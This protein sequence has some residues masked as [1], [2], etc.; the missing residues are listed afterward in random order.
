MYRRTL[1]S[2][3]T[4]GGVAL[5]TGCLDETENPHT[6]PNSTSDT[7]NNEWRQFQADGAHTGATAMAGPD[8]GGRIRWWSNTWGLSTAPVI[9]D[10]TVYAGTGLQNQLVVALDE[11]TGDTQWEA[12]IGDDIARALAVNDGTVYAA[13]SGVYALN[14]ETGEQKWMDHLDTS[15]GLAFADDTVFTA[16]GGGGPLVALDVATG[17][18]RWHREIHTIT[19]PTV[20]DGRVFAVGN[21]DLLA[22]D[23]ETGETEW[24]KE[25]DRAGGPPTVANGTVFVGTRGDLIAHDAATGDRDWTLPGSFR[26]TDIAA[27][28]DTLYF[29]GRQREDDEWIG[30]AFAVDTATGEVEWTYGDDHLGAG[31][32]VGTEKT[33]YVT[34]RTRIYA[35][36]RKTGDLEWWLRFQWPVSPPAIADETLYV[37]VGGRVMAIES[38]DGHAGVWPS[39]AEP[40]P[41]RGAAPAEPTYAETDFSFGMGG[42]D[43]RSESDVTVDEDA[44]VAVSFAIDGDGVDEDDTVSISLAIEN[45]SDEVLSFNTGAP[46]PFGIFSLHDDAQNLVAWTPA[47]EETT[48][49]HTSPHLGI[50]GVNSIGLSTAIQPGDTVRETYSI[51]DETHGIQPGTYEFSIEQTLFPADRENDHDGWQL[52]VT[53]TVEL[54]DRGTDDGAIVHELV[55]ADEVELPEEFMG[56]FTVD[57]LAPVTDT[58]P[59]LIEVTLEN[60]TDERSLITSMRR[61]PFASS[62]GLGPAARRLVLLPATGYAPGFV[63]RTDSGWWEPAF[64]PHESIVR[65][66]STTA[67]DPGERSTMRFIVTTHPETA[68]PQDGDGYAFEQ[69]FGDEAVDVPWGFALSTLAPDE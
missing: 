4:T 49:V 32:A 24:K 31:S 44:P 63:D 59:G 45:Q 68:D 65:G 64:L 69:G 42:F 48:H 11:T 34:T 38:G 27:I 17:D 56:R 14:A 15:W 66:R 22:L 58:H 46:E 9:E 23:A 39:D 21:A 30:R 57:V 16:A 37:S 53:G 19:T 61:W 1:L 6:D 5:F 8:G 18:R 35:F 51:S 2:G 36:D 3:A 33:V 60:V 62:V 26:N 28:D 20:A 7:V 47:Y 25:I 50:T 29:P 52:S 41:D 43:V 67:Y 54:V 12:P 55:V 40:I 13:A 10:G